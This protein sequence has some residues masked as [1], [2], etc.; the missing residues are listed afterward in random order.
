M[1]FFRPGLAAFGAAAEGRTLVSPGCR[2]SK[3]K[4]ARLYMGNPEYRAWPKPDI[5]LEAEVRFYQGQFEKLAGELRDVDFVVDQLVSSPD[6]IAGLKEKLEAADGILVI[7]LN[8]G[9]SSVLDAILAVGRPTMVFAAPYSGHEWTR[10]GVLQK[11]EAGRKLG[12]F[13]TSDY[14]KLA[15]AIRPFRALHHLREAKILNVTSRSFGEYP[16]A[17]K[18]KFGTEIKEIS[19][20]RVV[21]AYQAVPDADATAEAAQWTK[22]AVAVVEPNAD[23]IVKACRMALAFE[24]LL[25]EEE[26]T[27][28][29]AD[30][31][32]TMYRPLCQA[33]AYPCVGFTRLND[34]GLGGICESDLQCAMTHII[35]QG[36]AGKPG[37][38]SDPT[39][40][41][42][43]NSIILAHCLGTRKMD[44]PQAP[45]APYKLRTIMER[46]E[47]V[48]P[49]VLMPTGKRV[50]QAKLVGTELMPYFTGEV[51]AAPDVDRGCRT[52]ITV[53][54]DGDAQFLWKNWSFGL[55]RS[56][57]FGDITEDLEHF[58]RFANIRLFDEASEP[59]PEMEKKPEVKA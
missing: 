9:I 1:C 21:Q 20:E 58:C 45:A 4:V 44:G 14:G 59:V 28:M 42:S 23:E 31:Y 8:M 39:F 53:K 48:V 43:N 22:G 11:Q 30:C 54:I 6:D 27:V 7:H 16:A 41:E 46:Q 52:K 5:D 13:L 32:G 3:V 37:F 17:V 36:L 34:M 51:I 57:C 35:F 24:K 49:Q 12:C 10:F 15:A 26:A 29:T 18:E 56:T 33:Y 47:G 50:T 55:H 19:L 25:D 2:K 38:I 40:D